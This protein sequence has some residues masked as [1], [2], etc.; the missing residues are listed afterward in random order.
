MKLEYHQIDWSSARGFAYREAKASP[1][2]NIRFQSEEGY[3]VVRYVRGTPALEIVGLTLD[4][5]QAYWLE[6]PVL[7]MTKI[8]PDANTIGF[9]VYDEGDGNVEGI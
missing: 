6:R 4:G 2:R 1:G 3:A 9:R 5:Q 8:N 7:D